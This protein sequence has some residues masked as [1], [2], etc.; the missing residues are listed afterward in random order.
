MPAGSNL[1]GLLKDLLSGIPYSTQVIIRPHGGCLWPSIILHEEL[2]NIQSS[3]AFYIYVQT[4]CYALLHGIKVTELSGR[5]VGHQG[6]D[7][8]AGE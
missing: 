5:A 7:Q 1:D 4:T 3:C 6:G 8:A 2:G